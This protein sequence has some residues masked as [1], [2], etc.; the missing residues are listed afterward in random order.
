MGI[1]WHWH[2]MKLNIYKLTKEWILSK[3]RDRANNIYIWLGVYQKIHAYSIE[4]T[5][6]STMFC[7]KFRSFL[8]DWAI[9]FLWTT[10]QQTI[11]RSNEIHCD[12]ILCAAKMR[13]IIVDE[14]NL[15]EKPTAAHLLRYIVEHDKYVNTN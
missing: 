13:L 14:W 6:I 8:I 2:V 4:T 5:N 15:I 12:G 7:N 3:K 9:I 10:K 1:K 11:H